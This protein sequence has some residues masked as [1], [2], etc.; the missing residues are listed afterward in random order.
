MTF[1]TSN[2]FTVSIPNFF[3]LV[4]RI[5]LSQKKVPKINP[6]NTTDLVPISARP[7][8]IWP[9]LGLMVPDLAVINF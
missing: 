8:I 4:Y 7:G 6:D 3:V 5:V 1:L 2:K 9:D